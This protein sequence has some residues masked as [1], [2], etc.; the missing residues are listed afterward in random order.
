MEYLRSNR[1]YRILRHDYSCFA[2]CKFWS[3][4]ESAQY[5]AA[6]IVPRFNFAE[7]GAKSQFAQPIVQDSSV[8][9]HR[10]YLA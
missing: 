4:G 2:S 9:E 6:K 8:S 7:I 3:R 10:Q 5:P 1:Y